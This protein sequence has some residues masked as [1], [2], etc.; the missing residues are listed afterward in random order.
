MTAKTDPSR[1]LGL[2]TATLLSPDQFHG[3]SDEVDL[4][5]LPNLRKGGYIAGFAV[6]KR[7]LEAAQRL[8]YEVFNV[9]L[10]EGLPDSHL[11]GLDRDRFD[12]QMSHLVLFEEATGRAVGTYRLQTMVHAMRSPQGIYSGQEY[13]LDL[14]GD[15]L[16]LSVE[17]GR[18]CIAEGH[19]TFTTVLMLWTGIG[20]FMKTFRQRYVFGC[21]SLTTTNP[22]D[23]WRAMKTLRKEK[24]LH[25][26]LLLP[27]KP[28]F[29]CGPASREFAPDLGHGIKLPK[30]FSAYMRLGC[31]VVSEPALDREFQTV[32]FLVFIDSME[33]NLS[34]LMSVGAAAP[35]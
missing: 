14:L 1:A 22:D 11:S 24:S 7:S 26:S 25:P 31:K 12:D 34:S 17:C 19:R 6:S 28:E 8:R 16:A 13:E 35:K 32:D 29:S 21:C 27:A 10:G 2:K 3:H 4:L 15:R 30:L 23:G 18:A 33:V 9:E 20:V 5:T